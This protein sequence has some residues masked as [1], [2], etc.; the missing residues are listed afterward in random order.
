MS[1]RKFDARV[2][3]SITTGVLLIDDFSKVHEAI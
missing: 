2:I 1:D 3:G